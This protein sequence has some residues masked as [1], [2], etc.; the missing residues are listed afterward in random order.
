MR[1]EWTDRFLSKVAETPSSCWQWTG[2][3]ERNGYARFY[4]NG[5]RQYAH[6]FAYEAIRGPIPDGLVIDHLCR[7]RA[8][9][10][11]D[12][13]EAVTNR[14]NILRGVGFCAVRAKQQRC[15]RG[16][17]FN[18][19]NTYRAPNGTRKCRTCKAVSTARSR[20][21]RQGV[22]TCAAA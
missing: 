3:L 6:R 19:A 1:D 13:L 16:H 5:Q 18:V 2:C 22:V 21:R 7:N 8:C 4:F 11:P 10:N 9:A 20:Q 14:V 15:I 12:H 17:A